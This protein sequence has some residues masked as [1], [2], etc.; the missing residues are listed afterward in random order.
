MIRIEFAE[1]SPNQRSEKTCRQHKDKRPGLLKRI[2]GSK[3]LRNQ[4]VPAKNTKH[5]RCANA[6]DQEMLIV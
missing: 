1:S 3:A 6:V 4:P 2:I 5:L